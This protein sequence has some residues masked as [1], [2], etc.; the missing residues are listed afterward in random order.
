LGDSAGLALEGA[1]VDF[2]LRAVL[3]EEEEALPAP[4]QLCAPPGPEG[5][6]DPGIVF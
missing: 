3:A 5:F 4:G 1:L 6:E 2:G